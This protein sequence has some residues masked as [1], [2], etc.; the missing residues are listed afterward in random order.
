M[1]KESERLIEDK[2]HSADMIQEKLS[3]IIEN[4]EKLTERADERKTVLEDSLTY[5][6]FLADLRDLVSERVYHK[7]TQ[8]FDLIISWLG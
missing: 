2:P 8:I 7:N 4:W 1:G 6:R 3:E 5:Q